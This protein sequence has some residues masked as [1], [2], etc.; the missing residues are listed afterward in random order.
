MERQLPYGAGDVSPGIPALQRGIRFFPPPNPS[1]HQHALRLA[2]LRRRR[3]NWVPRFHKVDP[4]D[5]LGAPSTP[6][7]PRFRAG[8]QQTCILT[9][10]SKH[11]G[12]ALALVVHLVNPRRPV[13]FDD[14]NGHSHVFTVSPDP[15]P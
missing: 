1:R 2:C 5:D 7:A 11:R 9:I 12:A 6:V 13:A 14:A 8:S 4:M 3:R 15:G 10:C